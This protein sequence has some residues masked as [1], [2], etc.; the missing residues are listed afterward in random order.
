M[1]FTSKFKFC[2]KNNKHPQIKKITK[3][4]KMVGLVPPFFFLVGV[5]FVWGGDHRES[6]TYFSPFL[7][8]KL[9]LSQFFRSGH[10]LKWTIC[11]VME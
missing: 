10:P 2:D 4:T 7:R 6:C 3:R 1:V 9:L 5:G 8:K 11:G